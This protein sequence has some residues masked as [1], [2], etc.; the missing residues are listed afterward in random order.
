MSKHFE[1][2]WDDKRGAA[3]PDGLVVATVDGYVDRI[4]QKHLHV[5]IVGQMTI[6]D[7]LRIRVK[8]GEIAPFQI[9]YRDEHVAVYSNARLSHWPVG[10]ADLHENQINEIQA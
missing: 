3:V 9:N 1:V 6:L 7:E 4:K 5:L 10:L 8:R 2:V